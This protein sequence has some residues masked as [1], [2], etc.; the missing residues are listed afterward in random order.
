MIKQEQ[1]LHV[2][3]TKNK[4][5]RSSATTI[6]MESLDLNLKYSH[7]LPFTYCKK[8]N[9]QNTT[10]CTWIKDPHFFSCRNN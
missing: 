7:K 2:W 6:I 3:S 4:L 8:Y 1:I 9:K 10:D 5:K